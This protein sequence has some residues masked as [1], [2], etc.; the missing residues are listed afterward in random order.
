MK[1]LI[2]IAL[3][4]LSL[5]AC[6]LT[7]RVNTYYVQPLVESTDKIHT[8]YSPEDLETFYKVLASLLMEAST[9]AQTD[10]FETTLLKGS[11]R[12]SERAD[13]WSRQND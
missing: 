13:Y 5:T 12:A 3:V 1:K 4:G 11:V 10:F 8:E 7:D 9:V 2:L 6:T